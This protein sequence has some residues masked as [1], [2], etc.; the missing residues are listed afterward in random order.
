MIDGK[1]VLAIIPARGGSKGLPGKNIRKLA[2]K[3]LIAW[4][5]Q[6]AK[7]SM[8]IDHVI[9]SSDD[10][11]IIKIAEKWGCDVPFIRPKEL[12]E[13]E[14]PMIEV[15]L[16]ALEYMPN[17]DYVTLLQ[18]T[19]PLRTTKDIDNSINKCIFLKAKACVSITEI[20]HNP[21]WMY[22]LTKSSKIV[23]YVKGKLI[24]R[25][26]DLPKLYVPNGAVYVAQAEWIKKQR[27]FFSEDTIGYIM[28]QYRS[29]DIDTEFDAIMCEN[30]L[31]D[32]G[33]KRK[34]FTG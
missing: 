4:A 21:F 5:I 17:C 13:D 6:C 30:L 27:T 2:G 7:S 22:G 28:P 15:V 12:S 19:S 33:E 3:P 31:T 23:P 11:R 24:D 14:S 10:S 1:T 20:K 25:R 26:Q 8:Y 16:H 9:L 34:P 18:P 32:G 29:I